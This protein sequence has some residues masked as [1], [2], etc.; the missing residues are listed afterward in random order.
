MINNFISKDPLNE[1]NKFLKNFKAEETY[2]IS[3]YNSYYLSGAK[4][5]FDKIYQDKNVKFYFKKKSFPEISEFKKIFYEIRKFKPKLIIAIGGGSVI[6]YAKIL[7]C[8]DNLQNLEKKIINSDF[9]IKK[10]GIKLL[11]IP[12][13][14]GSG[15][16]VTSNAVIY[17][18]KNKYS[19]EHDLIKPDYY[20]LIPEFVK[21]ANKKIKASS[22]FDAI[23]QSLESLISKKSTNQSLIYAEKSLKLS[24]KNYTS[25]LNN[26]SK[27]NLYNMTLAANLSGKAINIS[28][29]TAPHA[30]SYPFTSVF[31][32]SHGH[33]VSLT[34]ENF[35]SFNYKNI[36]KNSAQ[37]D[38]NDR[39]KKIFKLTKVKNIY[40]F[41]KYIKTL[42]KSANLISNYTK[43][44]INL[45][46]SHD[47]IISL[48]NEQRLSNNPININKY[49]L[50]QILLKKF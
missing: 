9:T 43:L 35:F 42:K 32:I 49:D 30:L 27:L 23:A 26:P 47:K 19:I 15:A 10:T 31:N 20:F 44:G 21:M 48:V 41:T 50:K 34:L 2:I 8:T 38:L 46:K 12:T 24:L 25:F 17:I 7:K 39:Y 13:T 1:L 4:K 5:I 11:T 37:F 29:T 3:G 6:D 40:E 45:E 16:E 36:E 22:G 28:K 33:A 14:A 18:K